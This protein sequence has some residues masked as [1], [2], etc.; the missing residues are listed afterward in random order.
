MAEYIKT[1][2]F[3]SCLFLVIVLC[4]AVPLKH[5]KKLLSWIGTAAVIAALCLYGYGYGYLYLHDI[6]NYK[7]PTCI[8]RTVFDSCRIF[9]GANN[10]SEVSAAYAAY[11]GWT[12]IYWLVHLLAMTTSA[13]AII[14]SLGSNL[15]KKIRMKGIRG[16]Y[17][18]DITLI[19]G[20]SE[21]T[22]AFGQELDDSRKTSILYVSDDLKNGLDAAVDSMGALLRSDADALNGTE[23]FLKSIGIRPG[24]R[25][26]YVYALDRSIYSNQRYAEQLLASLEKSGIFPE[27]TT[28]T[29]L[30]GGDNTDSSLQAHSGKYGYGSLISI[31]GADMVA[32][33]L[34]RKYPPYK[35]LTFDETGKAEKDFHAVIIGFGQIGQAVL[36]QLVMN[37]QFCGGTSRITVFAPDYEQRMGWLSHECREMLN[38]YNIKLFPY[39]GRSCQLYDYLAEHS[40]SVN[41]VAICVGTDTDNSEIGERLQSFL[42]RRG[43]DAPI[44]MC[45]RYGAA[46]LSA[47]DRIIAHPIYTPEILCTDKID[48][49]AM[50]LNQSYLGEGDAKENWKACSYFDRMSSRAAADFYDALLYCAGMTQ[51]EALNNWNPQGILL[52]NLAA[53]EHLRWNAFHYCMGFRPMTEQEFNERSAEYHSEKSKDPNTKYRITKDM[54]KRIHA[55]MIPW[56]ELDDY[57]AKENA[58]TGGSQD[59]AEND[60]KNV[61]DLNKVLKAMNKA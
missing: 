61:R 49:M 47:D 16:L 56:E 54:D 58:V 23:K 60:R 4:I 41:Y 57:S 14:V 9:V 1:I 39:D 12:L 20:L 51:E 46:H 32:R 53:S 30:D 27:Q 59:Y 18:R 5:T 3:A 19:Y 21:R 7:I 52:E 45:N 2:G 44:F 36:R 15:L 37:S 10:W 25:K 28:L 55:C 34:I 17:M 29:I 6:G 26:L 42:Q 24:K 31:N 33:I 38:H 43:C 11:P 8:L 35:S 22:L 48:R 40:A 13:S 50:V